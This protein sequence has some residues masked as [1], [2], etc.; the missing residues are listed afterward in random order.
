MIWTPEI[1]TLLEFDKLREILT[2]FS[3][4]IL[5]KEAL[6]SIVPLK[7]KEE[8]E[9]AIALV[10]EFRTLLNS[11]QT[12]PV[13]QN[14][15]IRPILNKVKNGAV[16]LSSEELII[17]CKVTRDYRKVGFFLG[18]L[19]DKYKGLSK[20]AIFLKKL[21]DIYKKTEKIFDEE[22]RIKDSASKELK[23]IRKRFQNGH[24]RL[25][26]AATHLIDVKK[27]SL[28]EDI[29]T[30]KAERVVL[31]VLFSKKKNISGI[32]HSISQTQGTVFIEPVELVEMNNECA[33]LRIEEERE[34]KRILGKLTEEVRENIE[35]YDKSIVEMM[36]IDKLYS[37]ASFS[38]KYNLSV[39]IFS[40]DSYL[41]IRKGKHPLLIIQKGKDNVVPFD[42]ELGKESNLLLVSGSNMGGKTVFLKSIGIITLMAYAGMHIPTLEDSIIPSI[43]N[44]YADI[45]D[46]Q[47]IEMNLSTFSSHIKNISTALKNAT[48]GSLVLLDEI[49]VGT[50][51]EEG[52]AIAMATLEKLTEKR[53]LTFATTHYGKLK[54]FVAGKKSMI[55]GS[56]DFDIDKGVPTYHLSYG[57]PG[58]SHGFVMAEK[59]G[60]P[61][62]VLS[63]ARTYID[64]NQLKT[65]ELICSLGKLMKEVKNEKVSVEGEKRRLKTLLETY[66]AKYNE[67]KNREKEF[68]K[69]AKKK[70]EGIIRSTRKEMENLVEKIKES[71]ASKES[72]KDSRRIISEKLKHYK[73][74]KKKKTD[75]RF[76]NGDY[77]YSERLKISGKI[78]EISDGYAKVEGEKFHFW[79]PFE[80]LKKREKEIKKEDEDIFSINVNDTNFEIDIR[81]LLANEAEVRITKF[82]DTAVLSG[83]LTLHIIHGKGTGVLR[84]MV[85]QFLKHDKRIEEYRL[86]YWNEG[87]SG[88]TVV[89]LKK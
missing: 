66:D 68:A 9:N 29:F 79:A 73:K 76:S 42:I 21:P 77:V 19:S 32:V 59:M 33:A 85:S 18:K 16:S 86:G 80:S 36:H 31:P 44:I 71:E 15:D 27:A 6:I 56:M 55:N 28:Q 5:G 57:V 41:S 23:S 81:G 83:L 82:I 65:D 84:E 54:H 46:E 70:A 49:G 87:G 63:K 60:F 14:K 37:I 13:P 88:V 17:I 34:V 43:D 45:G 24:K 26:K 53:A 20:I 61:E 75:V 52:M 58:S 51:P 8:R 48:R 12:F 2:S 47:S 62:E 74:E 1:L 78:V 67:I 50:D 69:E 3:F 30:T 11:T 38:E 89:K 22:G 25:I 72:I 40:N 4:S 35:F 7:E 10:K 39:P 64:E